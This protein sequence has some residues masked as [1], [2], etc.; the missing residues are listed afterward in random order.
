[1]FLA[2]NWQ[3]YLVVG[4]LIAAVLIAGC[5]DEDSSVPVPPPTDVVQPG[6]V[7]TVVGDV[8]GDGIPGGTIDT[9]TITVALA[10]GQKPVDMEKISIFYADTIRTETILPV[11]GYRGDPPTGYW[12][13]LDVKNQV[14][15]TN[16]RLEDQEQFTIRINPKAYLPA[17]RMMTLVVRT[18]DGAVPLTIRRFAPPTIIKEN[19]ILTPL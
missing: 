1:V 3:S 5:T 10:P 12:G 6:Q 2:V 13:I 18:S 17:N 7:L 14:G 19:N 11:E 16:N 4:I 15:N 8:T 9:I